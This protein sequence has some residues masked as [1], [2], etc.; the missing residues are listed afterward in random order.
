MKNSQTQPSTSTSFYGSAFRELG[1]GSKRQSF[2]MELVPGHVCELGCECC[3][4]KNGRP[5]KENG[6]IPY[7][8]AENY[9]D[10][11]REAGFK[12]IVLI[13]GEPLLHPRI[14]ELIRHTREQNL[15]PILASNGIKLADPSAARELA[16]QNVV[17][18]THAYFPGGEE[19]IDKFSGKNGYAEILKRAISNIK[20]IP[21]V[22][23]VMEMPLNDTLFPHAFDFFRYCREHGITPFIEISRTA[24]SGK[25]TTT[26]TP[27]QVAGLFEQFREYDRKFFPALAD[28]TVTP[29]AYGNKCTMS[30]TGLHVKNLGNG[31]FGGV[32][33]CCAQKIRHG[34]LT[35]E[36]LHQILQ[37][38]TLAVFADQDKYIVGPCR[39]CEIYGTCRGGCRGEAYLKFGCPRASS[40]ACHLIP[41]EVRNNPAIMAPAS[42]AGCPAEDCASCGLKND[43]IKSKRLPLYQP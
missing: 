28:R 22:K 19:I 41:A 43:M 15:T 39:D 34:D 30:I 24:D 33:S 6:A 26:I 29:P 10:Q 11:A 23:L 5:T 1:S 20:D 40:P 32:Y 35:K 7:S 4:K 25:P 36:P 42:C 3:Y 38:P 18:V 8:T 27:E 2:A 14:F 37:S 13:G 9:I 31:D 17:L 21:D 12:E 16:G